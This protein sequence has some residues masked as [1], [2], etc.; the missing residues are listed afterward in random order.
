MLDALSRLLEHIH[1]APHERQVKEYL[2]TATKGSIQKDLQKVLKPLNHPS[3]SATYHPA[4]IEDADHQ[5]R[6]HPHPFTTAPPI[7]RTAD[8]TKQ[9][10][11]AHISSCH[12][13]SALS[14]EVIDLLWRCFHYYASHP[15]PKEAT[16]EVIDSDAFDRAVAL[17]AH[18]G[19]SL[20][21]TQ[22]DGG[23]Y[24]R[25]HDDTQYIRRANLAR[26]LRSIGHPETVSLP[27]A[28]HQKDTPSVLSDV[29][30]VLATT[31][32]YSINQ[33]PS[34]ERLGTTARELLTEE[35]ATPTRWR[36][37]VSPTRK[38]DRT[39]YFGCFAPSD[40]ADEH[41]DTCLIHGMMQEDRD[42]D[43]DE[44]AGIVLDTLVG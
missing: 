9:S 15:F 44:L 35:P 16:G 22:D 10:L 33:A 5:R 31:Q 34:L 14:D 18:G 20:L 6:T 28:E 23:Y 4:C 2:E 41:L 30:D 17:L 26:M 43:A 1:L 12:P 40:P 38:W 3:S 19:T 36:L 21:G 11:E 37:R 42:S 8:W 29:V 13:S 27:P 25:N 32:P 24:W 7:L 39:R